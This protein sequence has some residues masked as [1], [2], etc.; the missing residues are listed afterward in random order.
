MSI[1]FAWRSDNGTDESTEAR[2]TG[3]QRNG[4]VHGNKALSLWGVNAA[5]IGGSAW[6][7]ATAGNHGLSFSP[8]N[9]WPQIN[10][11]ISILIRVQAN[12]SG[13]P[14][15]SRGIFRVGQY[16]A[17]NHIEIIHRTDGLVGFQATKQN[18]S[19]NNT[20]IFGTWNP[21]STAFNDLVMTFDHQSTA[22]NGIKFYVDG[23]AAGTSKFNIPMEATGPFMNYMML[24]R[25]WN[26]NST[27]MNFNEFV[28][29][30]EIIDPT[31]GG[32]DLSGASRTT[33]ISVASFDGLAVDLPVV[34]DVRLGVDYDFAA[35]TGTLDLP[36]VSDVVAGTDFDNATKT[37]TFSCDPPGGPVIPFNITGS[38]KDDAI[39][40]VL[41]TE[42]LTGSDNMFGVAKADN[43]FGKIETNKE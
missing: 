30:D 42:A 6:N 39:G 33:F 27:H 24:G 31:P 12:Y 38:I 43:I 35:K 23:V 40:S 3:G 9:N 20:G 7:I 14:I 37:G 29:W 10:S 21:L 28:I 25:C 26:A 19:G 15:A 5:A 8:Y 17:A 22:A 18:D 11:T 16:R 32:L 36:D 34:A 2:F 1:T 4:Y 13:N 41:T